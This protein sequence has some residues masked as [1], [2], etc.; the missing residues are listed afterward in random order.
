MRASGYFALSD[1]QIAKGVLLY[2]KG[3]DKMACEEDSAGTFSTS[4][5]E[6]DVYEVHGEFDAEALE[7]EAAWLAS[8]SWPRWIVVQ[9]RI[10]WWNIR[11][12]RIRDDEC[13]F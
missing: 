11:Y 3:G 10:L 2:L 13:P 9:L 1:R 6:P 7:E 8:L 12:R 5:L 4:E